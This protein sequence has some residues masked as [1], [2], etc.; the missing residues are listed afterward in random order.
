MME[1][2]S[3]GKEGDGQLFAVWAGECTIFH[4]SGFVSFEKRVLELVH[5]VHDKYMY[6]CMWLQ[7]KTFDLYLC[8]QIFLISYI[9]VY[10]FKKSSLYILKLILIMAGNVCLSIIILQL[11][12]IS[13]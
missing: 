12:S 13:L 11:R 5:L 2:A 4:G 6:L 7:L 9:S 10:F 8:F 3:F 1:A